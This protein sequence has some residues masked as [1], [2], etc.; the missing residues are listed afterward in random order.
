MRAMASPFPTAFDQFPNPPAPGEPLTGHAAR[1]ASIADAVTAVQTTI[2]VSGSADPNSV[3]YRVAQAAAAA[4]GA[5]TPAAMASALSGVFS[6]QTAVDT[7]AAQTVLPVSSPFAAARDLPFSGWGERYTPAGVSFN[8]L[9]ILSI[10]RSAALQ[11]SQWAQ[12]KLVVRTGVNSHLAAATVLAESATPVPEASATLADLVFILRDPATGSVRTLTDADF[13]GGEYFIGVYA[14][15]GL[16]A[17]AACGEPRGAMANAVQQHYY[18]ATSPVNAAA[19]TWTAVSPAPGLPLGFAHLLIPEPVSESY[20]ASSPT[21]ALTAA[22]AASPWP[23]QDIVVPPY[24][25]AVEGRECNVYLDNLHCGSAADYD[26]DVVTSPAVGKQQAERFTWIPAG[27][28]TSG[29]ITVDVYRRGLGIKLFSNTAQLRAA[30][31][32]A[33]SGITRRL[34]MIGDSLVANGIQAQTLLD[35][36]AGDVFHLETIGTQGSGAAKHEGRS[37]WTINAFVTTGSPFYISGA[38]N[39]SAYLANNSLPT[40]DWVTIALGINDCFS[41]TSDSATES[42]ADTELAKLDSLIASIKSAGA[43]IKVAVVLPSPPSASQDAF[44]ENY[45]TGQCRW[46]FK[47]NIVIWAR[48]LLAKYAGQEAARIYIVPSN[49]ALDTVNN[50]SVGA[51]APAN[52]RSTVSIARQNNGVHPS[53]Q[54]Y[55]QIADA[56]WAF[57]KYYAAT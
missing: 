56:I 25:Y 14:V 47:R 36:S 16:G 53:T 18:L 5:L 22:L 54:G 19:G 10:S 46:R 6:F 9:K 39:F 55:Q 40:P 31:A 7:T 44:A 23:S 17:L 30:A 32:G 13:V 11:S 35:I 1:H 51:S 45:A 42:L 37:G 8:A 43:A 57:L 27:A 2:G 48:K 3:E 49:V 20:A 41:Q 34:L 26:H 38:V 52:S 24:I 12:L 21:T 15:N 28:Q 50:M 4:R 33:G 29:T